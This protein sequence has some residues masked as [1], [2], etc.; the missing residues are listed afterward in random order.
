MSV[1]ESIET[2]AAPDTVTDPVLAAMDTS[3]DLPV[4]ENPLSEV[5]LIEPVTAVM[6]TELSAERVTSLDSD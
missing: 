4:A 6:V 5:M 2:P 3:P 1:C